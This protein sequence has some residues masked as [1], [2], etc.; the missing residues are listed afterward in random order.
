M[1]RPRQ[2]PSSFLYDD[3]GS[4]LFDAICHLP[5]YPIPGAETALLV[6]HGREI[7]DAAGRPDRAIELGPGGGDKLGIWIG[8]A[9]TPPGL[10]VHLVDVSSSALTAARMRLSIHPD[11]TVH[12]HVAEYESGLE[13]AVTRFP[14]APTLV[15]FLGSNI[16]NFDPGDTDQ[17]LRRVR[18]T[19]R[20]GDAFLL[21]ADLVKPRERLL[22]AYNDPLGVTAAFNRNV[23]TRLNREYGATFDEGRFMHR[24]LWNREASRI[25]MHLVSRGRQEVR[26]P[27]LDLEFSLEPEETIWTESSYK[28]ERGDI[29]ARCERAGFTVAGPWVDEGNGFALTLGRA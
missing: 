12:T 23:L 18:A 26:V 29:V 8:A 28:F 4:A 14:A 2:V 9:K 11:L 3:L 20:S 22:L 6:A 1:R 7:F 25:E 21:G 15:L 5:W 24:A 10:T 17:F 13:E 19:M 27:G 16:G